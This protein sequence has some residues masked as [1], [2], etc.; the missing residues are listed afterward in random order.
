RRVIDR[1]LIV[2]QNVPGPG[3][4]RREPALIGRIANQQHGAVAWG[5]WCGGECIADHEVTLFGQRHADRVGTVLR[6]RLRR[7]AEQRGEYRLSGSPADVVAPTQ[8]Q[9]TAECHK[10]TG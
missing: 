4:A 10:V 3:D 2:R 5:W 7:A 1:R 8:D 9:A 6:E